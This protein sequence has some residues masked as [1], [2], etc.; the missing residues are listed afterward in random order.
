LVPAK[1]ALAQ[2]INVSTLQ[3]TSALEQVYFTGKQQTSKYRSCA[4]FHA[5]LLRLSC[6]VRVYVV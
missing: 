3:Q 2:A 6:H 4:L 5:F 1:G